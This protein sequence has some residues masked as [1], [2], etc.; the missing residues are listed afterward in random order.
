MKLEPVK[1]IAGLYLVADVY[2]SACLDQFIT[3][4][5][6][7]LPHKSLPM[8]ETWLRRNY[9]HFPSSSAWQQL[10]H[11]V[12]YS[13]VNHVL[14][15]YKYSAMDTAYWIDLP[16]FSTGMHQDNQQ[17]KASLQVYLD[18][19]SELGTQFIDQNNRVFTVPYQKNTGYLMIN[20]GQV[21]GFP[22]PAHTFRHSTYTLLKPKS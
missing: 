20:L 19:G 1:Q 2:D 5:H 15:Y 11:S 4:D 7:S 9:K 22:G 16:G 17:V 21:H 6:S 13:E 3:E 10:Q 12:D 14:G 8:Q 18:T